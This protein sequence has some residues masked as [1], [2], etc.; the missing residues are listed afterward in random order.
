MYIP[1]RSALGYH[2]DIHTEI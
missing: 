1:H 2:A